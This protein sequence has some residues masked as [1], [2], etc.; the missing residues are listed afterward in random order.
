M[1]AYRTTLLLHWTASQITLTSGE[2]GRLANGAVWAQMGETVR[3]R[4]MLTCNTRMH[5]TVLGQLAF[6]SHYDWLHP[7]ASVHRWAAV[8]A[9]LN[10]FRKQELHPGSEADMNLS[11]VPECHVKLM[12]RACMHCPCH[13]AGGVCHC[14]LWRQAS[15]RRQLSA[16]VCALPGTVQCCRQNQVQLLPVVARH[17]QHQLPACIIWCCMPRVRLLCHKQSSRTRTTHIT[18]WL[19][20]SMGRG[21]A[22]SQQAS[23][24]VLHA[25]QVAAPENSLSFCI[26][27]CSSRSPPTATRSPPCTPA[28]SCSQAA[29]AHRAVGLTT[30]ASLLLCGVLQWLLL[31]A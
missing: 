12:R 25:Y 3:I 22:A 26:F 21:C 8:V 10:N 4:R 27:P 14:L 2:I 18:E 29:G 5:Q 1:D 17:Q 24:L 16:H 23:G 30:P 13:P 31:E 15:R 20:P 6:I 28:F 7:A 19:M 9:I 11:R